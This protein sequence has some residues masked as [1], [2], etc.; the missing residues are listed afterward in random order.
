MVR[1]WLFLPIRNISPRKCILASLTNAE[2]SIGTA[3]NNLSAPKVRNATAWG[4]APGNLPANPEA[5]KARHNIVPAALWYLFRAFSA[6][7][8]IPPVNLGRWPRLLH[9]AP[10]ALND[11][12]RWTREGAER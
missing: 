1:S 6:L 2:I 8:R 5:L 12:V 9:H 7:I 10:L 11:G 4:N 3:Q